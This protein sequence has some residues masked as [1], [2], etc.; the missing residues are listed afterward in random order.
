MKK[1]QLQ[2][3]APVTFPLSDPPD[4]AGRDATPDEGYPD[5]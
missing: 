1:L 5:R 4:A 3:H 2:G